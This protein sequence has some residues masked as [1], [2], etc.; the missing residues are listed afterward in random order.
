M[1]RAARCGS[2]VALEIVLG[3]TEVREADDEEAECYHRGV[4]ERPPVRRESIEERSLI[5]DDDAGHRIELE[6]EELALAIGEERDR[7]QHR[8]E[9]VPREEHDAEDVLDVAVVDVERG[10]QVRE[11]E[12]HHDLHRDEDRQ[13]DESLGMTRPEDGE[14]DEEDDEA[15]RKVRER[16]QHA[17]RGEQLQWEPH[18]LHD[19]R[20]RDDRRGAGLKRVREERPRQEADEEEDRVRLLPRLGVRPRAEDDAEEDPEHDELQQRDEEVPPE[21]EDRALVAR[22]E[23]APCEVAEELAPFDERAK[24]SDHGTS[25]PREPAC[26]PEAHATS[27]GASLVVHWPA[28]P[29][30]NPR[31]NVVLERPM[32]DALGRLARREGASLST[33]ARDLLRDALETHEDFVL[34]EIAAERERTLDRSKTLTHD[35][36]WRRGPKSKRR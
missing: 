36:V 33:K 6:Q 29:A 22:T 26:P 8:R 14:H 7:E 35:A 5:T 17:R 27:R 34:G 16:R 13:P 10:E 9:E 24:V 32:Y 3:A 4:A 19:H 11:A 25:M 2:E 21:P 31:V 28:M 15:E 20:V 30:K 1:P 18:L 12:V 23:L